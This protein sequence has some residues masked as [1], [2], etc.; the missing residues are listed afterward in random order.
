MAPETIGNMA[1]LRQPDIIQ[2]AVDYCTHQ[3]DKGLDSL[4]ALMQRTAADWQRCLDGVS[5]TQAEFSPAKNEWT[6]KEVVA[7]FLQATDGV[8]RQVETLT[9]GKDI[10]VLAPPGPDQRPATTASVAEL[11]DGIAAIFDEI[12]K[13]TRSLE[14]NAN[15]EKQ[16]PHPAFGALNITQWIAF[17]R[18]HGMDHMQQIDKNKADTGYPKA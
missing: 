18:L 7:H 3:A 9:H 8:N 11:S 5:D 2:K 15:L 1:P 13:L 6:T 12:V 17:Q 4:V 10:G 16:F 14:G